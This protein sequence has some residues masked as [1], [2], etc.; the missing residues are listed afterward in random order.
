VAGRSG[1]L[2]VGLGVLGSVVA[3]GGAIAG[4]LAVIGA[5]VVVYLVQAVSALEPGGEFAWWTVGYAV[6]LFAFLDVGAGVTEYRRRLPGAVGRQTARIVALSLSV[7]ALA[8]LVLVV[9]GVPLE[10]GILVQA[11]GLGA[12]AAL[13]LA[14][15]WVTGE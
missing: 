12:A 4:Q 10:R 6:L 3:I 7:A 15:A 1:G 2:V 5:G 11:A 8:G 13:M 14:V 9:A